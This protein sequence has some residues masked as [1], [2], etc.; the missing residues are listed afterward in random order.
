MLKLHIATKKLLVPTK[1]GIFCFRRDG[2]RTGSVAMQISTI[3]KHRKNTMLRAKGVY[4]VESDHCTIIQ[5]KGQGMWECE[6]MSY[7]TPFVI[8][9]A[10]EDQNGC[11]L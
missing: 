10:E 8:P 6:G 9:G 5:K 1:T 7:G 3:R 2:A 4:T 11:N